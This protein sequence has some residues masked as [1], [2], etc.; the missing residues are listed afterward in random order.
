MIRFGQGLA[1]RC[2]AEI[3]IAY[4][5]M[6]APSFA[7]DVGNALRQIIKKSGLDQDFKVVQ[8]GY[9]TFLN[10]QT[11]SCDCE[12]GLLCVKAVGAQQRC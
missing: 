2:D 3:G 6:Y 12:S 11:N 5:T 9:P 1:G 7:N 8:T 10:D 4:D